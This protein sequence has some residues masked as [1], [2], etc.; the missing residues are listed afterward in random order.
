[1]C[2]KGP[3]LFVLAVLAGL[4]AACSVRAPSDGSV[5]TDRDVLTQEQLREHHFASAYE[6]VQALRSTWLET[7]GTDSFLAPSQVLVYLDDTR[8]GGVEA[9][10]TIELANVLYIRH[11]DGI[12]ASARWG[13]GHGQGVI[14][15]STRP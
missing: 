5:R 14:L 11:L 12:T 7:R 15:V 8:L 9:L 6:A 1:M 2:R 4:T 13:L 3:T 10:R